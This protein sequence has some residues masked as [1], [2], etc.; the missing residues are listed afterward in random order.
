MCAV[1]QA[2]LALFIRRYIRNDHDVQSGLLERQLVFQPCRSFDDPH[3]EHFADVDQLV[4]IAVDFFQTGDFLLRADTARN[5]AVNQRRAEQVLVF[6]PR[7]K[8]VSE[9]PVF[10]MLLDTLFQL[11]AVVVDQ[12]ARKNDQALF[13]GLEPLVQE[14]R[15]LCREAVRRQLVVAAFRIVDDTSFGRVGDDVLQ[16]VAFRQLHPLRIAHFFIGVHAAADRGD[17]ALTIDLFAVLTAAEVERIQAL[18]LVDQLCETR[19]D[20]L[21]QNAFSVPAGLLVRAVKEIIDKRAQKVAFAKLQNLFR[22]FFQN[23]S[24]IPGLFQNGIIQSFHY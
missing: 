12:L 16:I 19:S 8:L 4:M 10:D 17:Y 1:E 9:V 15:Q 2:D 6:D 18:L 22:R 23:V 14:L 24:I 13:A 5:D 11:F 20:W 3:A 21:H 7:C